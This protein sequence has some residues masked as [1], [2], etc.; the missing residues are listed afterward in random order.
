M[1][2]IAESAGMRN[3]LVTIAEQCADLME[4]TFVQV[5]EWRKLPRQPA[6]GW[7][8]LKQS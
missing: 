5:P 7:N 4:Q 8:K 1:I 3:T 6:E 2:E